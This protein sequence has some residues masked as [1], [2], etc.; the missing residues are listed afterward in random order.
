[1][2]YECSLL[3]FTGRVSSFYFKDSLYTWTDEAV[4]ILPGIANL[5]EN[6]IG[7]WNDTAAGENGFKRTSAATEYFKYV[8]AE[9]TLIPYLLLSC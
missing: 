3:W 6:P 1:M 7:F 9:T 4:K 2:A 5:T 8:L